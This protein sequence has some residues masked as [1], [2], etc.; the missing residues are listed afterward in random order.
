M[1]ALSHPFRRGSRGW[2]VFI[3]GNHAT[4]RENSSSWWGGLC[5]VC[6]ASK[7]SS[8]PEF[9]SGTHL[10][11]KLL[12]WSATNSCPPTLRQSVAGS[13]SFLV[14][15]LQF[16]SS[17]FRNYEFH[18]HIASISHFLL[19]IATMSM[20]PVDKKRLGEKKPIERSDLQDLRDDV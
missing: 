18:P 10:G 8:E 5:D 6:F 13:F 1:V 3:C 20:F 19:Y 11:V 14:H 16:I 2:G 7:T 15:M 4:R 9:L 12:I 17:Y